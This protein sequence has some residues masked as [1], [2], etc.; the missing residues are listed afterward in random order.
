M[1]RTRGPSADLR[2][3]MILTVT[4]TVLGVAALALF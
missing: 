2:R 3:S 1:S 4:V